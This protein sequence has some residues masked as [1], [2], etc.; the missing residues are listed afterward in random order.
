MAVPRGVAPGWTMPPLRGEQGVAPLDNATPFGVNEVGVRFVSSPAIPENAG[1]SPRGDDVLEDQVE[2]IAPGVAE[3]GRLALAQ[4][5]L[6]QVK[7]RAEEIGRLL[8]LQLAEVLDVGEQLGRAPRPGS[9]SSRT[10]P[11]DPGMKPRA[12]RTPEANSYHN[13]IAPDVQA[14]L[15]PALPRTHQTA[16]AHAGPGQ[17]RPAARSGR[18]AST[19]SVS[20]SH[21]PSSSAASF[22]SATTPAHQQQLRLVDTSRMSRRSWTRR[23]ALLPQLG[24]ADCSSRSSAFAAAG[25]LRQVVA[26]VRGPLRPAPSSSARRSA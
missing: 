16:L 25:E 22:L 24:D 14:Q 4:D 3:Q 17:R 8:L 20:G 21:T 12:G 1:R 10:M 9:C 6:H 19:A 5:R 26:A 15:R 11:T 2:T 13:P 23:L 18:A 7:E